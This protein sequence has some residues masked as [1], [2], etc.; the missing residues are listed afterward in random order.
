MNEIKIENL[1]KWFIA[2]E[3]H[4]IE[5]MRNESGSEN[6]V[7]NIDNL[8]LDFGM[9]SWEIGQGK[10]KPWFFT[11]SPNGD[12]ERIRI[13]Q[14]IIDYAPNLDNWEFNYCKPAIDWDRTF[15]I[16]DSN[17]DE[18]HVDAS[19]WKYVA[20]P[21]EYGRIELILE[22]ANISDLDRDAATTA[23]DLF[24][25]NEVGE[26]TSIQHILS[27]DI[28]GQL[29]SQYNSRKT[30]IQNLKKYIKEL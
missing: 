17:M 22:A 1:W 30:G 21:D 11:I 29:D 7:E 25:T 23:A 4:I 28:I 5:A 26:E 3:Q 10:V 27:I 9:F 16:Y 19:N 24:V 12:R 15:I 13:S 18:H 20:L 8:I 14:E 2:N 6:I